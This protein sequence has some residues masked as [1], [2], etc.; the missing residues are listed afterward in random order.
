[1]AIMKLEGR[2][3]VV[4]GAGRG[5]GYAIA[6]RL[7]REG[8]AVLLCDL[9]PERVE[10]AVHELKRN[11]RVIGI[12]AD[13]S[14]E[15][16]VERLF[17]MADDELGRVDIL[18]NNAGIAR[19][20]PFLELSVDM[21]D[22]ILKVNLRGAFLCAK[23]AGLRMRQQQ[24]GVMVHVSST[25]AL[26]GEADM[27]HYNASK[28]GMALLSKT[29]AGELGQYNVRSVAVCPGY[30]LTDLS[31]EV[32]ATD[33]FIR[34]YVQKIPLKRYGTPEDVAAAVAFLSSDD[35]GFITGTEL[36]IDGGQISQQ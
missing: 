28:A 35:A 30:I 36:V 21:W 9:Q 31:R 6:S 7:L 17:A 18:V 10:Q 11:G 26:R 25:N 34:E 29:I 12:A 14:D 27:A 8:A 24:S 19:L 1:M 5:I 16:A 22:E 13:V 33:E 2:T 23:A 15:S 4:T 20:S 32:G 3:A